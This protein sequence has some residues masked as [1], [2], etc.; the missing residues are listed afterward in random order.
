MK[1]ITTDYI[2]GQ[3]DYGLPQELWPKL[4]VEVRN[5]KKNT[6]EMKDYEIVLRMIDKKRKTDD[7]IKIITNHEKSI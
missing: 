7:L 1:I 5:R 2:S 3:K 4:R 6:W